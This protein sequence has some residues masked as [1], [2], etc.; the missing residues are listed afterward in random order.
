[1]DIED[2]LYEDGTSENPSGACSSGGPT[3]VCPWHLYDFD[4]TSGESSTGMKLCTYPVRLQ[5]DGEHGGGGKDREVFV[6]VEEEDEEQQRN[7]GWEVAELKAISE[8]FGASN[9]KE[10]PGAAAAAAS[11]SSSSIPPP[12]PN[13]LIS[14]A[15]LILQTADPVHKVELTRQA[16]VALRTG[17]G[18]TS[19]RPTRGDVKRSEALFGKH[20]RPPGEGVQIRPPEP[21][22]EEDR[23]VSL[24]GDQVPHFVPGRHVE[25]VVDAEATR[26]AAN[27]RRGRA[28]SARNRAAMLHALAAIEQW[29]IDLAWDCVARFGDIRVPNT[30]TGELDAMPS[31]FFIDFARMAEDEAKHFSLLSQRLDALGVPFGS[32]PAHAG[33]WDSAIETSRSLLSRL[34]VIHLVAEARGLDVNPLTIE[35]FRRAGDGPS[36]ESL[37]IIHADEVTHVTTGHRW[38]VWICERMGLDPIET[39]RAEVKANFGGKVSGPFNKEDRRKAG[40]TEAYYEGIEGGKGSQQY[41][42]LKSHKQ[43]QQQDVPS[44]AQTVPIVA[45]TPSQP[46]AN[47]DDASPTLSASAALPQHPSP[48]PFPASSEILPSTVPEDANDHCPGV[49]STDAGKADACE[50]CPNQ[51]TCAEGPKGPDPDLPF[52][53]ERMSSVRRKILVLSGKG[54]VG[55]STFSAGLSWALAADEELQT[56]VMDVDVCGPS[57]PLLMGLEGATIHTSAS[58]WS[59]AYARENLAVMSIGFMLPSKSD[60]VI[61]R[62]PRKNG[63]IKQFLKDVEWGDLDYL[64]VDTPPGTSDEHLS[65]VQF[66]QEAGIDGAVLV[67]TPQEVALQDVRKEADFCRK[68]GLRVLGVVENMSGFVCPSCKETSDIFAPTT[69]GAERMAQELGLELLGKVPLDPRIGASCDRG[70]SFLDEY[71]D[72]PATGAYLDIV[73]SEFMRGL[74]FF[75]GQ[76]I[77]CVLIIYVRPALSFLMSPGIRE[78]L[79]D[80]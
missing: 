41:G 65:I 59:P 43:Q 42:H 60:A 27:E 28:G 36:V 22:S 3:I 49:E 67:T 57:I 35:K 44:P 40:M 68:V 51:S 34:A 1:M 14:A 66:L 9:A 12:L 21:G 39:F 46:P 63:L 54:G 76:R 37:E 19:I 8:A 71:P 13:T 69:G 24:V 73:Q 25:L 47:V 53:R 74:F 62:G 77:E 26:A 52:I 5:Q 78:L 38:F 2:L 48:V 50:G 4:L 64:V 20:G 70:E 80:D 56:G 10:V 58:G 6:G 31:E 18:F 61:W 15:L 23:R 30:H 11:S 79:G 32:L 33:L 7:T 17:Q 55:K 16:A 75:F 72:S 45:P 29:A